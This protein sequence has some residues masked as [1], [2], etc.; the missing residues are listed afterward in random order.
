M[1]GLTISSAQASATNIVSIP[2]ELDACKGVAQNVG[3]T[4]HEGG[5]NAGVYNTFD[6]SYP[7]ILIHGMGGKNQ[8][9]WGD[10]DEATDLAARIDS[11]TNAVVA[12]EFQYESVPDRGD[13]TF[14]SHLQPL[15]NAIDCIAQVS[16]Q[17]GGPGKVIVVGYSEG[18]ALAHGAATKKSSD[19]HRTIGDEIGQAVTVADARIAYPFPWPFEDKV[20]TY[21]YTP[22]FPSNVTVHSIGGNIINVVKTKDDKFTHEQATHSDGVVHASDATLQSTNDEGGGTH[23]TSCFRIY[24]GYVALFN[25]YTGQ[26]NSPTCEHGN[27]LRNSEETQWDI[28]DAITAFVNAHCNNSNPGDNS[29]N[30]VAATAVVPM[31]DKPSPAPTPSSTDT[32]GVPGGDPTGTPGVPGGDPTSTPSPPPISGCTA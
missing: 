15:A 18:S 21:F 9:Q 14:P 10:L 29:V 3:L 31:A 22:N 32:P 4:K 1:M 5:F 7:V 17:N 11:I 12:T 16:A 26:V 23:V 24:T 30:Q 27:L 25:R 19:G 8:G 28:V 6:K 2:S 13:L 20:W